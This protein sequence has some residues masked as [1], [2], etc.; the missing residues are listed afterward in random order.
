M[1][2]VLV[3]H[4]AIDTIIY[5]DGSRKRHLG[6]SVIYGS[7]AALKHKTRPVIVSLVGSDFP[8]EYLVFLARNGI[9]ISF[10]HRFKG[11][12]TRFKLVYDEQM[13]R[14]VY[15]LSRGPDIK[16]G[17]LPP[18]LHKKLVIVG[19]IA[20]EVPL[21][22]LKYISKEASMTA[23]D[24]QGYLRFRD[25]DGTVVLKSSPVL[26][27]IL[28]YADVL[29]AEE[30]EAEIA[31]GFKDPAKAA[32][33]LVEMGC[34]IALVTMGDRGSYVAMK[35]RLIYVPA[36]KPRK[37]VDATGCGDV[38]TTVFSIEYY[39]SGDIYEAAAMATSASAFLIEK[40]GV[41]GLVDRSE[42]RKKA[43]DV[44]SD[45]KELV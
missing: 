4:I 26:S 34:G 35:R 7:F 13:N 10:I 5:P 16:V 45:I 21:E 3:G 42:V 29:H 9:D 44:I 36:V 1:D 22:T 43:Q 28:G 11:R 31:T 14:K 25:S 8:D 6:G 33:K 2:A 23:L 30:Y 40:P 41:D 32:E 37:M 24:I 17:D 12:T 15:L 38:Y 19:A 39:R 18:V 20:G 27:E